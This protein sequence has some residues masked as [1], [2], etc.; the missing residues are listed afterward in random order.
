MSNTY[1]LCLSH[2]VPSLVHYPTSNNFDYNLEYDNSPSSSNYP[3]KFMSITL[4]KKLKKSI[5]SDEIWVMVR[6]VGHLQQQE[7]NDRS[8]LSGGGV[9]N[10]FTT[11]SD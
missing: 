3:K 10:H 11:N 1:H 9:K 5:T 6:G 8:L 4:I 2:P 7:Y